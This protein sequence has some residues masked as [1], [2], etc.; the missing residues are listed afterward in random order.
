[1]GRGIVYPVCIMAIVVLTLEMILRVWDPIGIDYFSAVKP[2]FNA[3]TPS[4][5]FSYIH[6]P[7]YRANLQGVEVRI[8]SEG[9]RGEEFEVQRA[10]G[11]KRV[12]IL[13]DS[14][15]FGWGAEEA[16]IF[17]TVLQNRFADEGMKVEVVPEG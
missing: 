17:P 14:V 15:V 8:N 9:F 10:D 3:M 5:E 6:T 7:G 12:M 16:D 13:G 2:Y 11:V 1:L 4:K